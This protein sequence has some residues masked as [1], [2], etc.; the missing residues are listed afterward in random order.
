M[1]PRLAR[2]C[3]DTAWSP[4]ERDWRMIARLL[5]LALLVSTLV[6]VPP[7]PA[8][9]AAV[10]AG[11]YTTT[12]PAGQ[13]LPTGCGALSV[14]PRAALTAAAPSGPVPTN[15]WWSSILWKKTDCAFGEPLHAHPAAYDT[16]PGGLGISYTTKPVIT[17]SATGVGEYRFPFTR[18]VLVG[19]PGLNAGRV[20]V[21]GWSD[22]TVSP[23]WSDGTRTLTATIGHG[24]PMSYYTVSGGSAQL[25]TDGPPRIWSSGGDRIGFTI[26]DHDYVAYA[27]TGAGW[28][29]DGGVITSDLAGKSYFT[30]ALLPTTASS[31]D[32]HRN[33]LADTYGRYAH[34]HVTGTTVA[35]RYDV[36]N[37]SVQNRLPSEH[38]SPGGKRVRCR[39]LALSPPVEVPV[40]GHPPQRRLRVPPRFDE[41]SRRH[42]VVQ[43]HLEIQRHPA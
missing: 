14:N 9:A 4:L 11:S 18:D 36:A 41:E 25:T 34:A 26:R 5:A 35:Y 40:G 8:S 12:L 15:D 29:V 33:A 20:M 24:L 2:P 38:Y 32:G 7:D 1:T 22:W 39:G 42:H 31:T 28:S 17:G 43:H 10:G 19:I 6:L 21:N 37:G 27:P 16:F 23:Q 3:P 30:V 13:Q